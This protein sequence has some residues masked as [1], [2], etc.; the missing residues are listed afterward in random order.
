MFVESISL[1]LLSTMLPEETQH[2]A[3][4]QEPASHVPS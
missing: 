3:Q 1:L 4:P 2:D